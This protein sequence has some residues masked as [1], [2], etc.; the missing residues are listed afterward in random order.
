MK[1]ALSLLALIICFPLNAAVGES[2]FVEAESFDSAAGWKLDTQFIHEV[3]SP[4]LL[5]HGL[6]RPVEDATTE[7]TFPK[8]GTYRVFV[9]TKDWVARWGA[10]GQPGR[11]Q[12]LVNN[13]PLEA[14]FGTVGAGLALAG[15]WVSHGRRH[16]CDAYSA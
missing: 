9:R 6:G 16:G 15:W 10:E 12:L 8:A 4:Y 7:V 1:Q 11:F 3:G 5:A 13:R 2:L 14:T